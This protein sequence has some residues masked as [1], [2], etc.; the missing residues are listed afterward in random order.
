M[1][2]CV[3]VNGKLLHLKLICSEMSADLLFLLK[4]PAIR[5]SSTNTGGVTVHRWDKTEIVLL[6]RT[7]ICPPQL[8][9]I[10]FFLT[11]LVSGAQP[12]PCL[13]AKLFQC[14]Q[15]LGTRRGWGDEQPAACFCSDQQGSAVRETHNVGFLLQCPPAPQDN[16]WK[17]GNDEAC[18]PEYRDP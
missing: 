15:P 16:S 7:S 14:W 6:P 13:A 12:V 10:D 1:S 3:I 4:L 8:R 17:E 5:G 9:V 2:E 11:L 18:C